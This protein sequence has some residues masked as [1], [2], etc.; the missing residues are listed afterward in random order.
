[1]SM[2]FSK[3]KYPE[4][5]EMEG[6]K[7]PCR[8]SKHNMNKPTPEN[9][10]KYADELE[11]Y[12]SE[13]EKQSK[14]IDEWRLSCNLVRTTFKSD[15]LESFGLSNHPKKEIFWETCLN[16][17]ENSNDFIRIYNCAVLLYPLVDNSK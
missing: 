6:I 1:M 15:L 12:E 3:Y 13:K 14:L 10:R 17:S 2:D 4:M 8:P 7:V 11:V 16:F 5:P 9:W